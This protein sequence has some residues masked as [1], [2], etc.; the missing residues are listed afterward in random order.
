MA[1]SAG[2]IDV[3]AV[4]HALP[5]GRLLLRDISFRVAEGATVALVG[6]NGAGKSTLLKIIAGQLT[7]SAG[8]ITRSGGL[9]VMRQ[10]VGSPTTTVEEFLLSMAPA[11]V[12]AAAADIARHELV[13]MD[14]DDDQT[15]IAYATA[16]A[17]YADAGGYDIEV[18]WDSCC[19]S[20]LGAPF[21]SVKY[22]ELHT[23]SGGEQKRL[24][25]EYLLDG[26]EGVLLLDEPD[27]FLDVPGK[28]WLEHRLR[29]C[30]KSVLMISHDRELLAR[31][32]TRVATR[33]GLIR[34][35]TTTT[36]TPAGP[37]SN[38]STN[39][40]DAGTRTT[41]SSRRWWRCTGRRQPS[42]TDW[43]RGT[44]PPRRGCASSKRPGPPRSS[45]ALSR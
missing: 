30:A 40:V 12:R 39:C 41:V 17:D 45:P 15:A 27:N 2:H 8:S 38:A 4:R 28:M 14:G 26:P 44:R 25:L 34:A 5:D 36:T 37:A 6:A 42:T 29:E 31:T 19:T 11:P 1:Q 33:P 7:P 22:R 13:L 24:A 16:L 23:L 21:N 35:A 18:R 3:S 32:A 10:H 9:A 20:A 43:P